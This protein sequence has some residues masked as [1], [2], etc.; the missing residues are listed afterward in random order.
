M[1][2]V[3][4]GSARTTPRI[5]AELQEAQASSRALASQYGLNP[6]TILKWR[7]RTTT[8]DAPMGPKTPKST[9]LTPAEEA[10]IV[11]FRRRTL[12]ALDDVMGCLKDTIPTLSRSALHRCLQRHGISRLP[13]AED[14]R[15]KRKTFGETA[16]GYV[17]ID[18]AQLRSAAGVTHMFLAIDRVSKFA[19]VEFHA[20]A[21]MATGAA[22]IRGVVAAFPYQIRRV[23][24]DNGVAFT[25]NASTKYDTMQHPFDRVCKEHG[26]E[27]RLTK[28]YH[29][30]TNG[31]AERMNRTVKEATTKLFHYETA[32]SLRNHILAFVSAYNFAKHLKALRWRTPF[33]AIC[34]AYKAD[35]APFKINPHH[36]IPG[37]YI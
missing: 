8:T 17:H 6:K 34:D 21:E 14:S 32:E 30:W 18:S 15:S 27:H 28:P 29:P 24:T 36:L 23:L 22:F 20:T 4:H 1:A 9:V 12:L 31:Q 37:P 13:K 26:I 35:P 5:R 3:L 16:I 10:I 11:E 19:Y 7:K 33:Q 25:K 2:S